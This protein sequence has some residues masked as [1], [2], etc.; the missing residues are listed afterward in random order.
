MSKKVIVLFGLVVF[1]WAMFAAVFP[2]YATVS[3]QQAVYQTPTPNPDGRIL[4]IVQENDTLLRI[5]LLT[6]VSL[7]TL[8]QLNKLKNDVIAP[9]QEI[10]LGVVE[11]SQL[12]PT[13]G[14]E[15][16]ATPLLP[17]PTPFNG[18]GEIC[19]MLFND[20]NGNATRDDGEDGIAG[21]AISLTDRSGKISQTGNTTAGTDPVCYQDLPEGDYNVSV[22]IPDGY[23]PT[24]VMNYALKLQAGDQSTLDF[25]AQVSSIVV[26]PTPSEG[27]RSPILGIVGII[28]LLGGAGLGVY[29]W[30][31][32]K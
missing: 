19:V 29:V 27:G 18:T 2:A 5:S 20:V 12:T 6:G 13:V 17:S 10:L 11:P 8:R 32:N 23:N 24:T 28:L 22:A 25:G 21:G 4:Y 1:L 16:T 15:M 31:S 7:D 30:R 3:Q 26:E 14:P 9:G